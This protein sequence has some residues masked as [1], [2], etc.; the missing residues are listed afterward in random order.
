MGRINFI[1]NPKDW[2][3]DIES[4]NKIDYVLSLGIEFEVENEP[5]HVIPI[6]S[7]P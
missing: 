5:D 1:W 6:K 4:I 7:S 3:I 2:K